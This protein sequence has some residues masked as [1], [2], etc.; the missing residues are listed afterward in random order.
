MGGKVPSSKAVAISLRG[1]KKYPVIP[2]IIIHKSA[3]FRA[4]V[5]HF[6]AGSPFRVI[7][8][9]ASLS[10]LTD[11]AF[12]DRNCV[13]LIGCDEDTEAVFPAIS[14]L[15]EQKKGLRIIVV[16]DQLDSSQ[17]LAAIGAGADGYL[18]KDEINRDSLL[19]SLQLI[20]VEGVVVPHGFTKLLNTRPAQHVNVAAPVLEPKPV[21][22]YPEPESNSE[23]A[24]EEDLGRLSN[25]EHLILMHLTQGASNKH[26]ARQLSIAEATVKVHVKSLLR[27]IRVN[28]RTQAAMWAVNNVRAVAQQDPKLPDPVMT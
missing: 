3:L 22:A 9:Y 8:T 2:S 19:V 27:K 15:K 18:L 28:N 11:Q 16:G 13:A 5:M 6:L 23:E 24:Q 1:G 21:A 26:I 25:R 17:L 10:E 12:G 20:L 4:G 14:L 7:A